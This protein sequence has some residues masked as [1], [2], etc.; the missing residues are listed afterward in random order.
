MTS[1]KPKVLIVDD[2]PTVR[3]ALGRALE[4]SGFACV[5]CESGEEALQAAADEPPE[6]ALVDLAMP[7]MDGIAVLRGL[8]A[9]DA[10]MPVVVIT[11][12]GGLDSA[13]QAMQEGA[14]DYVAKPLDLV[15]LRLLARH[16]VEVRRLA[17]RVKALERGEM[18]DGMRTRLVGRHPAM[19]EVFK[20]IGALAASG[21]RSTV[22]VTGETGTG[23]SLVAR[24]LHDTGPSRG[25]QFVVMACAGVPETLVDAELFGHSRGAFTGADRVRAGRLE[26]AGEGTVFLDE[27]GDLS[28][29][30][31][32]KLLR[33]LETGEFERLGENATLRCEARF[34]AATHRELAAPGGSFRQD[35]YYRLQVV[36][37]HLPS[38]RER[39]EDIPLLVD[40]LLARLSAEREGPT[41]AV[42]PSALSLLS[43]YAWP[44][45][46]RELEHVLERSVAL[47]RGPVLLPEH[48]PEQLRERQE[49]QP[50]RLPLV[51]HRLDVARRHVL[52]LFERQFVEDA[53]RATEGNVT[54]A[55]ERAGIQRQSFQRLMQRHELSSEEFRPRKLGALLDPDPALETPQGG[56]GGTDPAS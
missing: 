24:A 2:D 20:T 37:I 53:L 56:S 35:L 13:V 12:F 15:R 26:A 50:Q 11:A 3:H 28:P 32:Q 51:S 40:H 33:V 43:S 23:K 10:A 30:V 55:A 52:E 46:V 6:L 9:I 49:V 34:I 29:A 7:G 14:H 47:V 1:E 17:R 22:L 21:S 36:R 54:A 39:R 16:A 27:I 19:V 31:Q 8:R 44:G 4:A 45:N 48:L 18:D 41:L 5:A 42:S 38:L 25:R